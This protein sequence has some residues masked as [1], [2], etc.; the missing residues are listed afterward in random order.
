MLISMLYL[1]K[2][3]E[4]CD[5]CTSFLLSTGSPHKDATV[6]WASAPP[7]TFTPNSHTFTLTRLI[8]LL[9]EQHFLVQTFFSCVPGSVIIMKISNREAVGWVR[10]TRKIKGRLQKQTLGILVPKRLSSTYKL[11]D[12]SIGGHLKAFQY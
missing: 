8:Q 1:S 6:Y 7:P 12:T 4:P 11:S 5:L 2:C 3:L 9:N 10:R